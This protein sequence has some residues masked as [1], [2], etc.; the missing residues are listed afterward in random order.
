MPHENN[1]QEMDARKQEM[2][3]NKANRYRQEEIIRTIK[4]LLMH[5]RMEGL[6]W[7]FML[8]DNRYLT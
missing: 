3:S 4:A 5:R 2:Y 7:K 1:M 6:Q 8:R